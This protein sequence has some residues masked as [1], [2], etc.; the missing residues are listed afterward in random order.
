MVRLLLALPSTAHGQQKVADALPDIGPRFAG[1]RVVWGE[2]RGARAL[3]VLSGAPGTEVSQLFRT[4]R[5]TGKHRTQ[6]FLALGASGAGAAAVSSVIKG[7]PGSSVVF[8]AKRRHSQPRLLYDQMTAGTLSGPFSIFSG[9]R[10]AGHT[11]PCAGDLRD[12]FGVDVSGGLVFSSEQLFEC[13][14]GQYIAGGQQLIER[15]LDGG[16][17]QAPRVLASSSPRERDFTAVRSEGN[18]VAWLHSVEGEFR[19]DVYNRTSDVLLYSVPASELVDFDVQADGKLA[20]LRIKSFERLK[21]RPAWYSPADP[22]PHSLPIPASV[23]GISIS[24]NLIVFGRAGHGGHGFE[25]FLRALLPTRLVASTLTGFSRPIA[26]LSPDPFAFLQFDFD[27]SRA[28]WT[29]SDRHGSG[30]FLAPVPPPVAA[31]R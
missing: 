25:A 26:R 8:A 17:V 1:P 31:R 11:N 15:R 21:L 30:I 18:V 6:Q 23:N 16:P 28:T 7:P 13:E 22:N 5:P 19:V 4:T 10:K 24:H 12:P 14:G 3:A 29:D 2:Q 20:A 27:G 9:G